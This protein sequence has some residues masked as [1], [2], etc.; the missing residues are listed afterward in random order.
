MSKNVKVVELE[1]A[2]AAANEKIAILTA[3]LSVAASKLEDTR[4]AAEV[5]LNGEL[6]AVARQPELIDLR[7][8]APTSGS[9]IFALGRGGVLVPTVWG[10]NESG[11]FGAWM[12]YPEMPESVKDWLRGAWRKQT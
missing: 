1:I 4:G 7:V 9:R 12:A 6:R 2:L 10:K 11:F 5:R 8:Q 3:E